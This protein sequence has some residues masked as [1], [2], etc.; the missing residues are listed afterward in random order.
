MTTLRKVRP[1]KASDLHAK[2]ERYQD[3]FI[4]LFR[5]HEGAQVLNDDSSEM[6]DGRGRVFV[7]V[8][9][10]AQEF[11]ISQTTFR[12]WLGKDV[13]R[14]TEPISTNGTEIDDDL[15]AGPDVSPRPTCSCIP[16]PG[17]PIHGEGVK[18]HGSPL[19]NRHA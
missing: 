11:G 9:W 17:C 7:T 2:A 6:V 15:G 8:A 3:G 1:V 13:P 10:F 16:D 4:T 12:R 19:E 18:H 14:G 5:E